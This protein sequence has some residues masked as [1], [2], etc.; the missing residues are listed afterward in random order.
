MQLI[1]VI[2]LLST[3]FTLQS[4]PSIHEYIT[5]AKPF[6]YH[7]L[8]SFENPLLT[9]PR[10]PSSLQGVSEL[11]FTIYGYP[12][13]DTLGFEIWIKMKDWAR[14]WVKDIKVGAQF[15]PCET[16]RKLFLLYLMK[17]FPNLFRFN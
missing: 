6:N 8:V 17:D 7:P 5:P 10:D 12:L 13:N 14:E 3:T 4:N 15:P 11:P 16:V 1:L 2:I 9:Q